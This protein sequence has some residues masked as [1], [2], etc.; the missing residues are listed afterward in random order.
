MY[1]LVLGA[2]TS[3]PY[4]IAALNQ[5][6]DWAFT[7]FL[8][9]VEDGNSYLAKMLS[10]SDGAWLFRSPYS[11]AEQ[12][13]I[14]AFLPYLLLG[15]LSTGEHS[16]LVWLYHL[17]RVGS[18]P[19]LVLAVYRFTAI[20]VTELALKRWTVIVATLGGGLGWLILILGQ[21][22]LFGS[23]PLEFYSPE[24]FGFLA[25]YGIPHLV[26]S[27]AALLLGLTWYLLGDSKWRAGAALLVAAFIHPPE[28]LAAYAALGAHAIAVL[29][30]GAH[31]R[32]WLVRG[33]RTVLPTL[34][35][36]FYLAWVALTDSYA[37]AWAEQNIIRSP[38][39]A[40]YLLAFGI[41]LP[42]AFLGGR[43]LLR[44]KDEQSLF[45]VSWVLAIPML[46]Y[47]PLAIQRR[48]PEGGWVALS[49][50]AAV[51]LASIAGNYS[52]AGRVAMASLLIPS[53]VL[54][55]VAGTEQALRPREPAFLPR[56]E[57]R[58]F[59]RLAETVESGD[60]VL[61]SYGTGN[62]LPAWAPIRVVLGHGPETVGLAGLR[63]Q[64]ESFFGSAE[65]TEDREFLLEGHNVGYVFHG[66]R[67]IMLGGWDPSSWECLQLVYS[68]DEY[69]IYRTCL[70]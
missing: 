54:I 12:R 16:Q 23:L 64:V 14:V 6:T 56:A 32:E 63:P 52:R 67:E 27:R 49:V 68:Q 39:P 47:A 30:F 57:A 25:I 59:A 70:E 66:P 20:F 58:A 13:G 9:A 37:I 42:A 24:T 15:K 60:V 26:L 11:T 38:H 7:G 61:S 5:G 28:L 45:P 1:G 33:M 17:F 2:L 36:G 62:P 43:A 50:L 51:G 8:L 31:K 46:A 48:L 53:A 41:M 35:L 55:L 18:I 4:L 40:L 65:G 34:P 69:D 19:L 29:G 44:L 21:S 22:S 10:G 3:I